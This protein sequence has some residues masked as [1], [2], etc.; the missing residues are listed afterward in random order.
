MTDSGIDPG[1]GGVKCVPK[2]SH[3]TWMHRPTEDSNFKEHRGLLMAFTSMKYTQTIRTKQT[4]TYRYGSQKHNY[5]CNVQ[6]VS[7]YTNVS[8]NYVFR[9]LL[10][11]PSSGWIP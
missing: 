9:P 5:I 6:G 10:V 4:N 2:F 7:V 3:K 11:R 1:G 8:A